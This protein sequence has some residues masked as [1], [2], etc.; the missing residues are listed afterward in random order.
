[1]PPILRGRPSAGPKITF[2]RSGPRLLVTAPKCSDLLKDLGVGDLLNGRVVRPLHGSRVLMDFQGTELVAKT[3]IPLAQG[4]HVQGIVQAKGPPLVLKIVTNDLS[5]KA[6]IFMRFKSL[7]CR[8]LPSTED[9]PAFVFSESLGTTEGDWTEP[10][11]RWLT[12]FVLGERNPPDPGRVRAAMIHGGMFYERKVRQWVE[13]GAKANFQEGEIDLKGAAL[14]LLGQIQSHGKGADFLPERA[15]EL[16]EALIGRIELFQT[17]NWLARQEGL[18]FVFQ[19]PLLFGDSLRTADLLVGLSH[20]RHGKK[21]GLRILLLLDMGG[22]GRFQIEAT[23]S[24][25]G[26]VAAIGV[27]REETVA[28]VRSLAGELK[29]GL[30]NQELTVVGIECFLLEKSLAK[31]DL[32]QHL[33]AMD[34]VEGLNIRV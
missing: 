19:I 26:V 13:A 16:L 3:A 22:L 32:F 29:K 17:A 11:A 33:L 6:E 34:E 4:E 31:E 21:D 18:G 2:T 15:T 23:I 27:D 9:H 25:K 1:M 30:E 10:I 24:Q 12:F 20:K 14:R 7:A 8:L 5:D 28:L